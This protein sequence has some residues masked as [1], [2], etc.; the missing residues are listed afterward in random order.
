MVKK[1]QQFQTPERFL[2]LWRI[3]AA[4]ADFH[5]EQVAA[6]PA[7][8]KPPAVSTAPES[9]QAATSG[10]VKGPMANHD[11]DK[12]LDYFK[13]TLL[14]SAGLIVYI[15][16]TFL[17]AKDGNIP[18]AKLGIILGVISSILGIMIFGA[19]A[20]MLGG[21]E[22]EP[23]LPGATKVVSAS[24]IVALVA[25]FLVTGFLY[26]DKYFASPTVADSTCYITLRHI[27]SPGVSPINTIT[28]SHPC[29]VR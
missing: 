17:P 8:D 9:A 5:A 24:H 23:W 20:R 21:Q 26:W 7:P 4:R 16:A 22:H 11:P 28:I 6:P 19:M 29:K 15:P 14:L 10:S 18:I 25:A 13:Y 3:V 27:R 2:R 12:V 1:S